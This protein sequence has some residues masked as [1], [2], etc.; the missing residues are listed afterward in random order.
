MAAEYKSSHEWIGWRMADGAVETDIGLTVG[1]LYVLC[2]TPSFSGLKEVQIPRTLESVC[3]TRPL[4]PS[5]SSSS[6]SEHASSE[7][8][9]TES[10][11]IGRKGGGGGRRKGASSVDE[12]T[13]KTLSKIL[14]R[15]V[16]GQ[17][18]RRQT[19]LVPPFVITSG[20]RLILFDPLVRDVRA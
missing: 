19:G 8:Y 5:S 2:T 7:C 11:C 6:C 14:L 9:D 15:A 3:S 10:V 12:E 18:I 13:R 17:H 20:Y 4:L 16:S 1:S